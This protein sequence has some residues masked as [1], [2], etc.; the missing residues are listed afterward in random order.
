MPMNAY[1]SPVALAAAFLASA[2]AEGAPWPD[3]P[4]PPRAQIEWV[5]Q[6]AVVD[7][8]PSRI[9]RFDSELSVAEVLDYYRTRWAK[10][11]VG[12][13]RETTTGP[14]RALSTLQGGFQ[15]VVQ[16][17]PRDKQGSTGLLSVM[18][19][20]EARSDFLP[21]NWPKWRDAKV[22]Q[23][24]TSRDGPKRGHLVS[25]VSTEGLDTNVR[26]WRQEW[27]RR[28][29]D[30]THEMKQAPAEGTSAWVGIFDRGPQSAEV[31]VSYREA[32]RRTYVTVNLHGPVEGVSP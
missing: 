13:P 10:A 27:Q 24:T 5:A 2:A 4:A 26:R 23:V 20:G 11:T 8:L 6:D 32:D 9:E 3:M 21:H 31:A 16:V 28:G 14:W 17:K 22:T 25:M 30:L 19:F 12:E 15:L 1:A 18:N 29:F 7:G